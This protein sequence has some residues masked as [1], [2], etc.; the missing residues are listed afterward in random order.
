MSVA[1]VRGYTLQK[2]LVR[3]DIKNLGVLDNRQLLQLLLNKR[4]DA[5]YA[6]RDVI[7]YEQQ[8]LETSEKLSYFEIS[9]QPNYVCVS[10]AVENSEAIVKDIN[11]GLRIIRGNGLYQQI[12]EKYFP[13]D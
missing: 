4:V 7:R 2:E 5:I 8:K 12:R 1:T 6:Y 11:K 3:S 13:N 9:S 10:K